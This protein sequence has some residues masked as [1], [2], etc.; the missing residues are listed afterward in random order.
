MTSPLESRAMTVRLGMCR[1]GILGLALAGFT[2]SA[3]TRAEEGNVLSNLFK[4]G[5]TTVPPSQPKDLEPA[6]CPSVDIAEGGAALRT[7]AGA[8]VRTQVS[9]GRVARECAGREDGS[10]TVKV[11]VEARVLLGP[12]DAP[13]RY[14]VPITVQ[15]KVNDKVVV[16]R[17]E[18]TSAVVGPGEAQ[19]FATVVLDDIAVPPAMTADY[20][21]QVGLGGKGNAAAPKARRRKPAVAAAPA[22]AAGGDPG[23]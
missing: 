11:G 9:L 10:I 1:L 5:G 15:I 8:A 7:L 19:G 18:R 20:E 13:G 21:I 6:Y 17:S 14:E 3:P 23:Q 4:Y 12:A 2:A 16:S 22:P